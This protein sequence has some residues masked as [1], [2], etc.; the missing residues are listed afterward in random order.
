MNEL[1]TYVFDSLTYTE[2]KHLVHGTCATIELNL[3]SSLDNF[4]YIEYDVPC[5]LNIVE[6]RIFCQTGLPLLTR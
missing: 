1:D 5:G 6:K 3:L 4:G 2:I